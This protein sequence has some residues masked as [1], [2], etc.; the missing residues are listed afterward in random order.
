MRRP[1]VVIAGGGIAGVEALLALRELA[2]DR[3]SLEMLAPAPDLVMRPLAVAA[4]F[5]TEEVR[6]FPLDRICADQQAHRRQE[7]V[8][9]VDLAERIVETTSGSRVAYDSLILAVGA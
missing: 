2:G 4:P 7:A 6:R 9:F 8:E 1:H 5:G 3:L